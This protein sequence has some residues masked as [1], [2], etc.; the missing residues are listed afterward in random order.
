[1]SNILKSE[2]HLLRN[3]QKSGKGGVILT[4]NRGKPAGWKTDFRKKEGG[5]APKYEYI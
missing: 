1:M 5:D 3:W 4:L 2:W